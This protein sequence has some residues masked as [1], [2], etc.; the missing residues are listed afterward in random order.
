MRIL[1]FECQLSIILPMSQLTH[2]P[3]TLAFRLGHAAATTELPNIVFGHS[4]AKYS[5]DSV[6]DDL[7]S[8]PFVCL[9]KPC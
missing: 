2:K 9:G 1:T 5:E 6:L 8:L 4:N 3:L 7:Y